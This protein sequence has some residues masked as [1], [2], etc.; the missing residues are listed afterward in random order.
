MRFTPLRKSFRERVVLGED[1][2]YLINPPPGSEQTTIKVDLSYHS[3]SWAGVVNDPEITTGRT[4]NSLTFTKTRTVGGNIPD[5]RR[6]IARGEEATTSLNGTNLKLLHKGSIVAE[7]RGTKP[8][9]PSSGFFKS[10]ALFDGPPQGLWSSAVPSAPPQSVVDAAKVKF[11]SRCRSAQG[12]QSG[13]ALA[14]L[15][16]TVEMV[17]HPLSAIRRTLDLFQRKVRGFGPKTRVQKTRWNRLSRGQRIAAV[18]K[19]VAGTW[20]EFRFGWLPSFRDINDI[21]EVWLDSERFAYSHWPVRAVVK[22]ETPTRTV[23]TE[24]L[25][26]TGWSVT[27]AVTDTTEYV[28]IFRGALKLSVEGEVFGFDRHLG[29]TLSEVVP[30]IWQIIPWSFLVDYVSNVEDIL[31]AATF[32]RSLLNWVNWTTV[33]IRRRETSLISHTP[34]GS[35]SGYAFSVRRL[36]FTPTVYTTSRVSRATYIQSFVPTFRWGVGGIGLMKQLNLGALLAQSRVTESTLH[37]LL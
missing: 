31:V 14:E 9:F 10:G 8:A 2:A 15:R 18:N 27:Y 1:G 6:R 11:I 26:S 3:Q 21:L 37:A 34:P 16:Q 23:R 36:D 35:S 5:W 19:A 4:P 24:T 17:R 32:D 33:G 13:T 29:L 28:V 25:G 7:Q 22:N 12:S 20:L 30:T